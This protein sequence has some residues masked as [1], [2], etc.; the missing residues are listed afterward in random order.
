M[1]SQVATAIIREFVA[2]IIDKWAITED[3]RT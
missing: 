1:L 2:I 3:I